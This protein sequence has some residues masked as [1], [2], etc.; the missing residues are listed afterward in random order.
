MVNTLHPGT[1]IVVS[2][3]DGK[4][5]MCGSLQQPFYYRL[6]LTAHVTFMPVPA[7]CTVFVSTPDRRCS[8]DLLLFLHLLFPFVVDRLRDFVVNTLTPTSSFL[9]MMEKTELCDS[10]Q[11]PFYY[12]LRLTAHVTFMPAPATCTALVSKRSPVLGTIS[13][14]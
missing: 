8:S 1:N 7:T 6:R 14:Y 5:E 12:R 4:T 2:R 3:N 10:L 11:Q 13:L 9:G